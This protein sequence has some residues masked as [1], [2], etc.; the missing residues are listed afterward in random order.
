MQTT[1][2]LTFDV[3]WVKGLTAKALFAYDIGNSRSTTVNKGY[4]VYSYSA[5]NDTYTAV[6]KNQPPKISKSGTYSALMDFQGSISYKNSFGRHNVEATAVWEMIE[7]KQEWYGL[8]REYDVYTNDTIDQANNLN[9][10]ENSGS[11]AQ[12]RNLS[13]ITRIHYD[14]KGKYPSL[15]ASTTTTRANILST[16]QAAM[17]VLG[18]MLLAKDGDFSRA[19]P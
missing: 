8:S 6:P 19:Y 13:L 9:S 3:P 16:S 4:Y 15:P 1:T 14:Y 2:S 5:E 18:D 10:K 11:D 7:R 17:M 12:Y